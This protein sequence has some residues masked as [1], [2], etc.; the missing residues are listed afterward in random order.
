[1]A[2]GIYVCEGVLFGG[3]SLHGVIASSNCG[4]ARRSAGLKG[5]LVYI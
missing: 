4:V 5:I 2:V 1:M 3:L